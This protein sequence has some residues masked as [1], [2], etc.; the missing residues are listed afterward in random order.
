VELPLLNWKDQA[1]A[2]RVIYG[3]WDKFVAASEEKGF[4]PAAI[5]TREFFGVWTRKPIKSL[6]EIEGMKFRSVNAELWIEITKL[7]GAVPNPMP[8]SEAYMAFKTGVCDG[9]VN[10]IGPGVAVGFPDVLKC[11]V[12][13]KLVLSR[14]FMVTSTKWLDSLPEDLQKIFLD[15]CKESSEAQIGILEKYLKQ[16][17]Q[18]MLDAGVTFVEYDQIDQAELQ[19]LLRRGYIFRDAYMKKK[20]PEIYEFYQNWIKFIEKETGR[21]QG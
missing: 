7:Y 20:G 8:F 2:N 3:Y 1:E 18:K 14:S 9:V 21:S 11:F 16:D 19:D 12:D 17:K 13:T 15:V 4:Y 5:D 6:T 10:P